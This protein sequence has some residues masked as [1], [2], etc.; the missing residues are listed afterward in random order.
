MNFPNNPHLIFLSIYKCFVNY[1]VLFYIQRYK[2]QKTMKKLYRNKKIIRK[3]M[4]DIYLFA[5][6]LNYLSF[7]FNYKL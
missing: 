5:I 2:T 1:I 3:K 4:N 6:I 7:A